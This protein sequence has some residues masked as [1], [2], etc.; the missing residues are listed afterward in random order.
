[1]AIARGDNSV[2]PQNTDGNGQTD[3][4]PQTSCDGG[5]KEAQSRFSSII[6]S[7]SILSSFWPELNDV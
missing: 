2:N 3:P 5:P 6:L 1:M 7:G 4:V